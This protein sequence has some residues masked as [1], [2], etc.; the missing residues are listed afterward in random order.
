MLFFK[1][2]PGHYQGADHTGRRVLNFDSGGSPPPQPTQVS[3]LSIPEYAQPY[4]ERILGR[5]EA[6]TEAPYQI[7]GGERFAG[8]TDA[9]AQARGEAGMLQAPGQFDVGTGL[10]GAAGLAGLSS[11]YGPSQFSAERVALSPL[12]QFQARGPAGVQSGLSSFAQPGAAEFYMSPY[13]Q[14]VTDVQK[15]SAI[16]EAQLAQQQANLGSARQGTYGGARQALAQAER[17]R[18]LLDRMSNIQA[19]GSQAAFEQAQKAFEAEQARGLQAGLQTQQLG[20]Q[21]ELENLRA[22]LGVQQLGTES[23]LQAQRANQQA[24][25]DAQRLAE[26]SRQFGSEFGLKG[27]ELGLRAGEGL[28]RLGA[29]EQAADLERLKFQEAMG[30]L[31]QGDQQRLYDLQYQDFVAQQQA[32]YQQI[33]FMSDILRGSGSL[34]KNVGVYDAPASPLQQIVGPGLLGL[35]VYKEFM[36]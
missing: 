27:Q 21:S 20:T 10:V 18:G 6:L 25:L 8:P 19:T 11:Q 9:Q 31:S 13:Q 35:G 29:T 28:A 34:A 12:E 30:Q 16:R 22:R 33:G 36:R 15:K 5:T 2:L 26:Q 17:E 1:Y 24:L 14:A 23:G 3:Q 7:Y 32:P 4:M